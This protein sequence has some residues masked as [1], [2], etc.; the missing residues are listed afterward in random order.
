MRDDFIYSQTTKLN[1]EKNENLLKKWNKK[2]KNKKVSPFKTW[3]EI[4]RECILYQ[5]LFA[6]GIDKK[7]TKNFFFSLFFLFNNL[8]ISNS[9]KI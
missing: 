4:H 2:N 6:G 8:V 3:G 1:V 9:L 7:S 5:N